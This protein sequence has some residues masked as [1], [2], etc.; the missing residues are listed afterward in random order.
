METIYLDNNATTVILPEIADAMARAMHAGYANPASQHSAGREARAKLE[1]TKEQ[2]GEWL[3][4]E[5]SRFAADQVLLTSGGT[6][7]NHL[8]VRGIAKAFS[9]ERLAGRKGRVVVS[10]IEHPSV[11]GAAEQLKEEG[12][13]VATLPVDAN[14]VVRKELLPE[15][16]TPD[17]AVVSVMLANN[18][19]GVLQPVAELAEI[20]RTRGVLIHTHATQV[21]GKL[22]VNF[23]ELGVDALTCTAHKFHG[24][25]GIGALVVRHGVKLEPLWQGGFQ[26]AGLRPGT[27]DVALAQGMYWAL[28]LVDLQLRKYPNADRLRAMHADL[29]A[30][31][32][33]GWPEAVIHGSAAARLPHTTC[34]S[35]PPLDRQALMMALDLAGICCSTGSACASGSSEPSPVLLAMGLPEEEVRSAVRFSLGHLNT[36]EEMPE[37]AE[38]ILRVCNDLRRSGDARLMT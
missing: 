27:E 34:I 7:A 30:R 5:M 28:E 25:R 29:E 35:F 15:L 2:I 6:E 33:A 20:C 14:G 9:K 26:Q 38:R 16:L 10:S 18:E 23:R 12:W 8:A 36:L 21:V 4:A 1:L 32:L 13:N 19:T 3:G 22:P 24:P 17:T 11:I 31:L 37:S